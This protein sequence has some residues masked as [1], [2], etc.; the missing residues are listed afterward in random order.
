MIY[1]ILLILKFQ[2]NIALKALGISQGDEV[3]TVAN[4][5]IST[6][7]AVK[8]N[9]Y[10]IVFCDIDLRDNSLLI[11]DLKKKINS[12]TSAVIVVHLYGNPSD[13]Y[14]IKKITRKKNIKLIED[15][16]QAH[17]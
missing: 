1:L 16:A 6:A 3:I 17:G 7:E 4:T 2:R 15:C 11:S 10:K 8:N 12:N 5:W 9:G 13:M 14:N